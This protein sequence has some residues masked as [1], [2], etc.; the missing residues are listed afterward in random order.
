[1]LLSRSLALRDKIASRIRG[2]RIM[3]EISVG[4]GSLL[5][6]ARIMD[7]KWPGSGL[8][9]N[10][11]RGTEELVPTGGLQLQA[12]DYL[13]VFIDAGAVPQLQ[14]LA[15]ERIAAPPVEAPKE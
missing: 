7:I 15:G 9:V 2:H 14:G 1:M 10:V 3:A 13:Y 6:A 5:A 11:R 12:G 4:E 8:L